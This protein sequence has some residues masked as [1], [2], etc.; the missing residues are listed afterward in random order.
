MKKLNAGCGGDYKEGWIN[1][2]YINNGTVDVVH[3]LRQTPLPFP[4][5]H[6]DYILLKD[7]MEELPK[8]A[9]H[10]LILDF[11]RLLKTDG[12]LEII[13]PW[14]Y[15]FGV[16]AVSSFTEHSLNMFLENPIP[17]RGSKLRTHATASLRNRPLFHCVEC[18]VTPFRLPF[19]P[20]NILRQEVRWLLRKVK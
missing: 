15:V 20:L 19:L 2:D 1:L 3:D 18:R 11:H 5:G 10:S 17:W 13:T 16:Q 4:D 14:G 7:T 12:E 8:E 6:F 9:I